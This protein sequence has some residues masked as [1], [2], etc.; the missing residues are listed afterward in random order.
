[1]VG[2]CTTAPSSLGMTR[3]M[4]VPLAGVKGVIIRSP[5]RF[6]NSRAATYWNMLLPNRLDGWNRVR[7]LMSPL[8]GD[9]RLPLAIWPC[10][11][12]PSS[13]ENARNELQKGGRD[14][15]EEGW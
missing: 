15:Q 13:V 6:A 4:S 14:G 3:T 7:T 1:M 9:N 5:W 11:A 10:K 8:P 12:F 2:E